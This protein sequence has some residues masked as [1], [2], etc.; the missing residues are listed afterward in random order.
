MHSHPATVA[1]FLTD[2]TGTFTFP[3]GKTQDYA[4]KAGDVQYSPAGVHLPENKGDAGME[5]IVIELKHPH[6]AMEHAKS[7]D[8][9]MDKPMEME[10]K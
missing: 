3:G 10:K 1:V 5:L 2:A 7:M 6:A 4:V 8:K 9:S